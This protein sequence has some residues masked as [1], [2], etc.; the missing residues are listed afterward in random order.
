MDPHTQRYSDPLDIIDRDIARLTFDVRDES[1]EK[2]RF[3]G[4][5]LL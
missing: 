4:K 5:H 1:S 2:L 3:K